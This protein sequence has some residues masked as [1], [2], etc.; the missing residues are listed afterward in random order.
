V[1]FGIDTG[2]A[3]TPADFGC[4][5]VSGSVRPR[6]CIVD[7]YEYVDKLEAGVSSDQIKAVRV[8]LVLMSEAIDGSVVKPAAV[9]NCKDTADIANSQDNGKLYRTFWTTVLMKNLT[10]N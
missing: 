8:C 10:N 2:P 1:Q 7:K 6:D 9:R 3:D 4:G 5:E